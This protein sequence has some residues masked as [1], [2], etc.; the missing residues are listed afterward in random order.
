MAIRRPVLLVAALLLCCIAALYPAIGGAETSSED[1]FSPLDAGPGAGSLPGD[2]PMYGHDPQRTNYNPDETTLNS[3]NVGFLTQAWQG[4][5]GIGAS[6]YPAFSAPSVANG[7][8]FVASSYNQGNNFFAFDTS[9]GQPAWSAFIGFNP[10][11]CFGVGIG[12][13]A[14]ISGTIVAIGGGDGAYYGLNTDNG[15]QL[16]RDP[17]NAG[18]TGFAWTSPLI[19]NGQAYEGVASD[20]D[21]PSVRGE[22]RS[23]NMMTGAHINSTYIVPEGQAGGGIWQSPALSID[24][25]KLIIATGEDY[26][27]YDG[28]YNR[29]MMVLN[30][31]TLQVLAA[32]KQGGTNGDLDWGTTPVLFHV[33]NGRMMVGAGHKDGTFYA[34]DLNNVNGGPVWSRHPGPETSTAPAYD[35][36]FGDGGTLFFSN[37]QRLYAVNPFNGSYRW[38]NNSVYIGE[39][40][41]S[42]AIANGLIYINKVGTLEILNEVNGDIVRSITPPQAGISYTVPAVSHGVVYWTSGAYLSAWELP[43]PTPTITPTP[44]STPTSTATPT[45]PPPP[46][47]GKQFTDVCPPDYFYAPVL[48]LSNDGIVS[49]YITAP[50]CLNSLWIPCFNPYNSATRGQISKIVALSAGIDDPPLGQAFQDVPPGATFYTYT[51]QLVQRGIASGYPCGGPGEPC[52]PPDNLPYFRSNRDVTRGQLSKMIANTFGWAEPVDTQQFEDV[53]PNSTFVTYIGRLYHRGIINGYQCGG[54]GEPCNPPLNL[55]YFRPNA[56]VTRG[57]TAKIVQLARTQPTATPTPPPTS[58]GT[59]TPEPTATPTNTSTDTPTSTPE[60][61]TTATGTPTPEPTATPTAT[62]TTLAFGH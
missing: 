22:I 9:T 45:P 50:P 36:T 2:W 34:Y 18:P 17:V 8:V 47:P 19:E 13:T 30:P 33:R 20:C 48:A 10:N 44:T 57:Q 51:Q 35:P 31:S 59:P 25:S 5:I 1:A 42:I 6:G 39:A 38:A 7:K 61:T 49:G 12:S 37:S 15:S 55:P 26:N 32:N 41:G 24:G 14:A 46:C 52:M 53:L 60:I 28:P 43:Q 21:N 56:N 54:P 4:T 11:E 58:T 29:A 23:V 3:A 16:W 40:H 27:G 62:S